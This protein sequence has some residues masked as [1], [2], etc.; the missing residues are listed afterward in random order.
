MINK[1]HQTFHQMGLLDFD[2]DIKKFKIDKP[3]KLIELFAGIGA[4]AKALE[5]LGINFEHYKICE[6]DP[7]AVKSYNAVHGTNFETSDITKIT[8]D[9]LNIVDTDKYEYILTY[10]FPCGLRGEKI[11]VESGYKNIE[12]VEVGDCVLTHTNT[13]KKVVKTMTRQTQGYY[14]IKYLGGE[15]LLTSEH[16]LY[17]YRD[18]KFQWIKVKD[19][20]LTDRVS[21]NVNNKEIDVDLSNEYLWLLGRYVAD[22]WVNKYLYNSVEFA[23]G[24][25]K[26]DEFL[27]KIPQDFRGRFKKV[28]KVC[29]EYRIADKELQQ[30]CLQFG[31]GAKNKKIPEW[32]LNLPKYKLQSF[33][34]GYISGDGHI[35]FKG[36]SKEIMFATT[37]FELFLG[38]QAIIAKL[39]SK[40]CSMYIRKDNRKETFNDTYNCQVVLSSNSI[41]QEIIGDKIVTRISEI[42]YIDELV[43]VFNFEVE[44]DNSYTINNIIV[45]NCQDL[46]LAG[47]QKGMKKGEGTRSGLLWEVERLLRELNQKGKNH[48]PK[49]LLLE[50]VA[51]L[52]SYKNRLDFDDWCHFLSS[53]GYENYYKILNAKDFGIPQNRERCFMVSILG[54]GY[55]TFPKPKKL[56]ICLKDML[57]KD[58]AEK[59]FLSDKMIAYISKSGTQNFKNA[60]CK[61]NLKIARPLTTDQNKRAGTTNYICDGLPEEFDL[62]KY[63]II[64]EASKKGYAIA[65]EGDGIYINRPHQK[66]GV[67]QKGMIQTIKTS[68]ND[69]G[70]VV[71][72]DSKWTEEQA[73][74][75][76]ADGNVKRYIDSDIV[77]EFKE[78]QI[79]DILFPNGYNK[80]NRVFGLCPTINSTTTES[81]FIYKE[82]FR[83][84]NIDGL[85]IRKLTPKECWRLMGFS[86]EDFDKAKKAG[87]SDS[88][89]YKQAG[90][91]IVVNVLEEIFKQ[92]L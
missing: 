28:Q 4:Q 7:Y 29:F 33:F 15:S 71:K 90:N 62:Q 88:K 73:K 30:Y 31:Q 65:E 63:F 57:E 38:L 3:I 43:D 2:D 74:M 59:Y 81:S 55:Y 12:D 44:T 10:S 76:T 78:G 77:D 85:R 26:E 27:N 92:M 21:F 22:G 1:N 39:Y 17:V 5:N 46:S 9:D 83:T 54:D 45:H 67:V 66:R 42:E 72:D 23:V 82:P 18:S 87:L 34:D 35:R 11:K 41:C 80:G 25:K 36:K 84:K 61:I 49:V 32:V 19:L 68:V 13:Y 70:V 40:I 14:R 69:I 52:L 8:A 50:N 79:A 16:P 75:I 37:S 58:V 47:K 86:D 48:L 53:L 91:S 51:Q 89:L 64:P 60:D 6:F 20:K 24:N 56:T